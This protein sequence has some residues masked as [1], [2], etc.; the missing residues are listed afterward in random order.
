MDQNQKSTQSLQPLPHT[1][2]RP[3]QCS[4]IRPAL[5]PPLTSGDD[6]IRAGRPPGG[7]RGQGAGPPSGT[8]AAL[9]VAAWDTC[10]GVS[11]QPIR[12]GHA[13]IKGVHGYDRPQR[14]AGAK[15]CGCL[16]GRLLSNEET[17]TTSAETQTR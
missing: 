4:T 5:H 16:T 13:G 6:L 11:R 12:G 9:W 3:T 10:S 8:K 1:H 7:V 2:T 17:A 14:H 15:W